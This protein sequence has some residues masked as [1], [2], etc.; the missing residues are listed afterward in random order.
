MTRV[1]PPRSA[2][3]G[4]GW[5]ERMA[6]HQRA[7]WRRVKGGGRRE[8]ESR[9]GPGRR[10]SRSVK[11]GEIRNDFGSGYHPSHYPYRESFPR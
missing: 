6:D 10:I 7:G 1:A 11:I 4:N 3:T 8:N 5:T 9:G 2:E